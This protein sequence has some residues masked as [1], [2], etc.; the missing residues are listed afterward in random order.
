[1]YAGSSL[2]S[3]LGISMC[4]ENEESRIEQREVADSLGLLCLEGMGLGLYQPTPLHYSVIGPGGY[5]AEG[6]SWRT[7]QL[8]GIPCQYSKQAGK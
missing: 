5:L 4:E 3:V 8:K 1:M 7:A 2:G 6:T